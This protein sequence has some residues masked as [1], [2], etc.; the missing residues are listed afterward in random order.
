[1]RNRLSLFLSVVSLVALAGVAGAQSK[2]TMCTDGTRSA[3]S[4]RGACSGHGG[5][6][7]AEKAEAKVAKTADKADKKIA[8][9]ADKAETKI[10]KTESKASKTP[11][12]VKCT[13]GTMSKG[14]RGACSR[15]G[16]I[17]KN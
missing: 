10:A 4:G 3:V 17:A 7:K 1:M 12:Q 8:K 11:A 5:V 2:T 15:H 16:G 13:D 9:T 6:K 14:G